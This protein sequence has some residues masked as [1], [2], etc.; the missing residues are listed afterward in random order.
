MTLQIWHKWLVI[1]AGLLVTITA[2]AH[3]I[4]APENARHMFQA[5]ET[6][7]KSLS[8]EQRKSAS[9]SFKDDERYDWH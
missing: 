2:Y 3:E 1:S 7:L 5:A 4:S 8:P 6:F 9:F